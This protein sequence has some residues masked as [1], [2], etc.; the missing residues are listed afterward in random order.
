VDVSV[1]VATFGGAEWVELAQERAV[2][3]AEAQAPTLHFHGPTLSEARNEGLDRV[4]SEFVIFLDADDELESGYVEAMAAGSADLRAP[5]VAYVR[6][7]V[8]HEPYVPR[9]AGHD[10]TCDPG[11]LV[12][13]NWL[14]VGSVVRTELACRAGGWHEWPLYEDWDLWRRCWLQGC[15]IEA[16]PEA[17]YRAHWRRDSRNRAPSMEVKNRVHREIVAATA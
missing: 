5:S 7:G 1:V 16:I 14:V 6:N 3:S 12:E 4:E 15:S 11:C 10:H 8:R 2:P 9:V 17:V 13:G